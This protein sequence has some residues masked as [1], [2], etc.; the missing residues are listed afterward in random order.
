[1]LLLVQ[2][3]LHEE[4]PTSTCLFSSFSLAFVL[5]LN[6]GFFVAEISIALT[7]HLCSFLLVFFID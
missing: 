5:S 1:M 3:G 6:V 4:Y 7:L 2:F